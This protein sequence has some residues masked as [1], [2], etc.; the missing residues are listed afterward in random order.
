[1]SIKVCARR[2]LH[3]LNSA[4]YS[5]GNLT[6]KI[7][8]NFDEAAEARV[9][10]SVPSPGVLRARSGSVAANVAIAALVLIGMVSLGVEVT[11]LYLEHRQMQAAADAGAIAAATALA[12]GD[13][14]SM[15]LEAQAVAAENGLAPGV[16]GVTVTTSNPPLSGGHAGDAAAVEVVIG[17][18]E[19]VG[20]AELFHAPPFQLK[21][22]AVALGGGGGMFCVFALDPSASGAAHLTNNAVLAQVFQNNVKMTLIGA[23]YFPSQTLTFSNNAVIDAT[24]CTQFIARMVNLANNVALNNDCDGTGVGS[25]GSSSR[26]VE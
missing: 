8:S 13:H 21:A 24:R 2:L 14:A 9:R 4:N 10:A 11:F 23:I 5:L 12:T 7:K 15:A 25:I 6:L 22:R 17:K 18:S 19:T 3:Y 20:L 26:L 1:M 16:S